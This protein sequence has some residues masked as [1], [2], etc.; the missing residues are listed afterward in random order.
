MSAKFSILNIS[1]IRLHM[2]ENGCLKITM[3]DEDN[4]KK[5]KQG[6]KWNNAMG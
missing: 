3:C 6:N 1:K 5:G 2:S 4:I